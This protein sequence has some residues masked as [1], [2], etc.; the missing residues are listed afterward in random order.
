MVIKILNATSDFYNGV[1]KQIWNFWNFNNWYL[2]LQLKLA[3]ITSIYKKQDPTLDHVNLILW[4][5]SHGICIYCFEKLQHVSFF[6]WHQQNANITFLKVLSI[7]AV[8]MISGPSKGYRFWRGKVQGISGIST[9][10][11][12]LRAVGGTKWGLGQSLR[13]FAIFGHNITPDG[14][15]LTELPVEKSNIGMISYYNFWFW[16]HQEYL[17]INCTS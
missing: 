7:E 4:F 16:Y 12:S 8:V 17:A 11:K 13:R 5:F 3:N 9:R 15:K 10:W 6:L 1:R 14:F 2:L